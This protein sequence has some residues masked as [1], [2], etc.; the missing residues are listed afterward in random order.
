MTLMVNGTCASE[1]R[2]KFWPMRFTYSVT[3]GSCTSFTVLSTCMA[4]CLPILI[5][6]SSEYQLPKPRPPI[7]RLPMASTSSSLPSCLTLLA[8]GSWMG[9]GP[10]GTES[11]PALLLLA[12]VSAGGV[13][14][15]PAEGSSGGAGVE[16]VVEP[17]VE[18]GEGCVLCGC[19]V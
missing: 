17:V 18:P 5:S 12:E 13:G 9:G 1:L 14:L 19:A 4:Y 7:L 10:V 15:V 8:S 2:T 11:L 3:T 6:V 16:L